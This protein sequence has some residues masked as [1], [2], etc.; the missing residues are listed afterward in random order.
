MTTTTVNVFDQ[1]HACRA[2]SVPSMTVSTVELKDLRR[3]L[4]R[5]A[6]SN[7]GRE[8]TTVAPLVMEWRLV[9]GIRRSALVRKT[10]AGNTEEIRV[11]NND[12][13][14]EDENEIDHVA[15]IALGLIVL[16]L[17]WT[18]SYE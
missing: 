10:G 1:T 17:T 4:C 15:Q 3:G 6:V 12:T 7:N 18:E 16:T 13:D 11:A 8:K 2:A 9:D 5:Y 14:Y